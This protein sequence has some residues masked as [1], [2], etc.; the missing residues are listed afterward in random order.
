MATESRLKTLEAEMLA[1][2]RQPDSIVQQLAA[3]MLELQKK[4]KGHKQEEI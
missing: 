2:K 1:I 4:N 3:L